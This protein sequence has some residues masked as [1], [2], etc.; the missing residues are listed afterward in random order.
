M[1]QLV[2]EIHP[3]YEDKIINDRLSAPRVSPSAPYGLRYNQ[4]E[5][6]F[7]DLAESFS[8]P[9]FPIHHDVREKMPEPVYVKALRDCME[10]LLSAAPDFFSDLTYF[11]DP[12]ETL[13]PCFYKLY[14][15]GDGYYLYLLRA[16]LVFRPLE[17][18][19]LE[20][21]GNDWTASYRSK[22]LYLDSD[23]IPLSDIAGADRPAAFIVKQTVSQ[24]SIGET[25]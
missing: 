11:F 7:I 12:G 9:S 3:G 6:L 16:N 24:T 2:N 23:F 25:G 20:R 1:E 13:R 5:E 8:V 15:C 21:G 10:G 17:M 18:E 14:R 22:R 19:L 4:N